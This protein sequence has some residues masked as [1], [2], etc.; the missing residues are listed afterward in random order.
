MLFDDFFGFDKSFYDFTRSVKD[1]AP[2]QIIRKDNENIII[3]NVLGIDEK[4][5]KVEITTEGKYNYLVIEGKTKEEYDDSDYSV[6]SRFSFDPDKIKDIKY[7]VKNGLLY[8]HL[9]KK[10]AKKPEI[11]VS[12]M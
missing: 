2:Y 5:L 8:I 12:K 6:N 7:E 9:Y 1:V 11:T 10:E 3:H 4:D